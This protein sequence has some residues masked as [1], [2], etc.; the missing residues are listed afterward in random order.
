MYSLTTSENE[1]STY[2][3]QKDLDRCAYILNEMMDNGAGI[4][5]IL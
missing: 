3:A 1:G 4:L 2:K 5:G